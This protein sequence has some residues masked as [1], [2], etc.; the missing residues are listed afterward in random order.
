MSDGLGGSSVLALER[1]FDAEPGQDPT[2]RDGQAPGVLAHV[3]AKGVQPERDELGAQRVETIGSQ[4]GRETLGDEVEHARD[5]IDAD[6]RLMGRLVEQPRGH[7]VLR[8]NL[9]VGRQQ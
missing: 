8:G 4:G 6:E 1:R 5:R 2:E 9:Q 3:Q 7:V